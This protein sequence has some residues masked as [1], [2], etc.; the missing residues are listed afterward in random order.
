[1]YS[2]NSH[3]LFYFRNDIWACKKYRNQ[4]IPNNYLLYV[5]L[6]LEFVVFIDGQREL[7]IPSHMSVLSTWFNESFSTLAWN[8]INLFPRRPLTLIGDFNWHA[9]LLKIKA[10]APVRP[11][12]LE[13]RWYRSLDHFRWSGRSFPFSARIRTENNCWKKI[14]KI[15]ILMSMILWQIQFSVGILA[16]HK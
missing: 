12:T 6:C 13:Q 10:D 1:M 11:G 2:S 3:V 4:S 8:G 7:T 9:P 16:Q 5:Y 14:T 15:D